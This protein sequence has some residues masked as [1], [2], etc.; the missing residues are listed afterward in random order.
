MPEI[1]EEK[2]AFTKKLAIYGVFLMNYSHNIKES[3]V[4]YNPHINESYTIFIY[5]SIISW[6]F[7]FRNLKR[8]ITNP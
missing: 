3:Q 6:P 5:N 7:V 8:Q 2:L 4:K 1:T